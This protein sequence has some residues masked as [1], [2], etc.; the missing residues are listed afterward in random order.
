[1]EEL[2]QYVWA[3]RLI[4]PGALSTC[5]GR[6]LHIIDPGRLNRDSGPDF[7]N[8]KVKI[9]G[10]LWCGNVEIHV[11]ASDWH[12]HGHHTDPAYDSVILHVV[13]HDDCAV[14][15]RT[16]GTEIPQLKIECA[17]DFAQ[18]FREF[19]CAPAS[20]F[21][22]AGALADIPRLYLRDWLDSMAYERLNA[23]G[24]RILE[25]VERFSGSWEDAAYVTTARALGF[26]KNSEPFERLAMAT[27]L[28]LLRKHSDSLTSLEALLFG[29]ARLLPEA[30][31]DYAAMLASEYDFLARKFQLS[32]PDS[33]N[34]KMARMRPAS[35]P[36]RRVALLAAMVA[37]GGFRLMQR[38]LEAE[39]EE[40]ARAVFADM[41]LSGYWLRHHTLSDMP[42]D[43]A[44]AALG[45]ASVDS[46]VINVVAPLL[47]AYGHATGN[48]ALTARAVDILEHIPAEDNALVRDFCRCGIDCGNA[49]VSQALIELR[50]EYCDVRKCLYC[51]IG[52]RILALRTIP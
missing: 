45:R 14:R 36:M 51:R 38:V 9:D 46:L 35:F 20:T 43:G 21:A 7:F 25:L 37:D 44:P 29:Q 30:P 24:G 49:F 12:R 34:W 52:H 33:Y 48:D 6:P 40:A 4:R 32:P 15:R 10:R 23:K 5:D 31:R 28:R 16:D 26:G 42:C 11:R 47:F 2:L 13:Q 8:A 18:R 27:P 22:C 1:M 3:H 17:A 41:R 50:R 19:T 39:T